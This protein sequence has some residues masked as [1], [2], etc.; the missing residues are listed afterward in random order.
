MPITTGAILRKCLF[1]AV[2]PPWLAS[3]TYQ[4]YL[5]LA[6]LT[7]LL[8]VVCLI[9]LALAT[10]PA[11]ATNT[12][13][14]ISQPARTLEIGIFNYRPE[15]ILRP[16]WVPLAEYLQ[17]IL[18]GHAVRLHFL[19][20]DEMATAVDNAL[21]DI[22]F[23]NP[24]HYIRLRSSNLLTGAIATQVTLHAGQP[25]SQL[26]G[27]I[28]KRKD[29]DSIKTLSDLEGK[30]VAI[31]GRQ[32]LGGY[33]AQAAHLR[34][35]GIDLDRIQFMALG[36]PHDKV[37]DAVLDKRA[38]AG[39]IRTGILEAMQTQG[40]TDVAQLEVLEPIKW[41][42]FPFVTSTT[43][44]PEWAIAALPHIDR[45][46]SRRVLAALLAIEPGDPVAVKAGIYGFTIPRDYSAVEDA[47][48]TLRLPP[49]DQ[50]PSVTPVEFIQQN[51]LLVGTL[52][53]VV[54]A[55][56]LQTTRL[57]WL[58]RQLL[59]ARAAEQRLNAQR[60][61]AEQ[62]R[63]ALWQRL[64]ELAENVPGALYQFRLDAD[65]ASRFTYA[66]P[67]IADV[68]GYTY[69]QLSED[70]NRVYNRVHPDDYPQLTQFIEN[71]AATL[72]TW[73]ATYRYNHPTKGE[74]WVMGSSTPTRHDDGSI[75]WH[76][77]I[78]DI[79]VLKHHEQELERMGF[80][81]ALTGIPNR[82][83]LVDRLHQAVAQAQR[84]N[85]TLAVCMLDLDGFKPVNDQHGHDAGDHL[86]IEIAHRLQTLV[87]AEDTVARLGGD[88]FTLILQ[89]PGGTAIFNK[90]LESLRS[91][92]TL[93]QAT[94]SVSASIGIAY[95]DGSAPVDA[96]DLLKRADQALYAAKHNGRNNYV[97]YEDRTVSRAW[98]A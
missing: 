59:A 72:N 86:L 56:A 40:R 42:N 84:T 98:R 79:T 14:D 30:K 6:W 52:S 64:G 76:G 90:I 21:L 50:A 2:G 67:Q 12:A 66:S 34:K 5:I 91:P 83:L 22:V 87:R 96:D 63:S 9:C 18:P 33:T 70:A 39:F 74:I 8:F 55:L 73:T 31:L 25:V 47:M 17:K 80:Y 38:D 93:G 24:A 88:E 46:T 82:R 7:K 60:I 75:T 4:P 97:V 45:D 41:P 54:I 68:Y 19:E 10:R 20:Q 61:L 44:Y 69:A 65:G 32:Y 36:N 53:A 28:I 3:P 92:V 11:H 16:M 13:P 71:S 85:E 51:L 81:D 48:V 43:L 49:F 95:F 27:V 57:A 35:K 23:T 94:V 62:E 78:Q 29:N 26:G 37:V 89:R 15:H 58:H 1:N 77:Y